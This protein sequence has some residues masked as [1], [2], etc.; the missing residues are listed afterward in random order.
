MSWLGG[1]DIRKQHFHGTP[2]DVLADDVTWQ[3]CDA[4]A[5]EHRVI[6]HVQVVHR[7]CALYPHFVQCCLGHQRFAARAVAGDAD[8]AML[9]EL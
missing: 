3:E 8:D 2:N 9:L 4:D 5:L 7:H 6:C 1:H